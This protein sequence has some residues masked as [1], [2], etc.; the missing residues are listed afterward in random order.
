M[1]NKT[2]QE[3]FS[4]IRERYNAIKSPKYRNIDPE[5]L[6]QDYK[7]LVT[8]KPQ[9]IENVLYNR[10]VNAISQT[11]ARME[12]SLLERSTWSNVSER[13]MNKV[14]KPVVK[15]RSN[16]IDFP[17]EWTDKSGHK[18]LINNG[19]WG[20]KNYM[21]MDIVAYMFLLKEG[22]DRLPENKEPL[23]NDLDSVRTRE[24]ELTQTKKEQD[25]NKKGTTELA[26]TVFNNER[27]YV[28]FRDSDFRQFTSLALNSNDILKLLQGTSRVE[29][30]LA[31]PIRLWEDKKKPKERL[32]TMNVFSRPFELGYVDKKVRSDGIVTEREYRVIFNTILGE[33]FAHNLKT[34]N[35][36]W[37]D[38]N[39][40]NL[41]SS[42]QVFYRRFILNNDFPKITVNLE[43]L[44]ERLGLE[45][46]NIT[47]LIAA[48]DNN[49]LAPLK[50]YGLIQSFEKEEGFRG[51]KYTIIRTPRK[52][53]GNSRKDKSSTR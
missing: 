49:V 38:K 42:A 15:K 22:G 25:D 50:S 2:P 1:N 4:E 10:L 17:L 16:E 41:P 43:T 26:N 37:L 30:K 21:V 27:Y 9:F 18:C 35:Y 6:K 29:F 5:E 45:N 39:F 12:K 33:L 32:Y 24:T 23:F 13:S 20:A 46:K 40:Y 31:F 53:L 34:G 8:L 36:D 11:L 48:I 19:Y 51:I 3:I 44:K 7:L 52:N 14:I 47:N 28:R